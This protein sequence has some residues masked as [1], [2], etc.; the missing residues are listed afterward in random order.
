MFNVINV[1]HGNMQMMNLEYLDWKPVE[2]ILDL[3]SEKRSAAVWDIRAMSI[4]ALGRLALKSRH[5]DVLILLTKGLHLLGSGNSQLQTFRLFGRI[6]R[7]NVV[8]AQ[9]ITLGTGR[10]TFDRKVVSSFLQHLR[11]TRTRN[12]KGELPHQAS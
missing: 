8:L 1:D 12:E 3:K 10:L 11:L 9:L 6:G 2:F 5:R 7:R 4:L